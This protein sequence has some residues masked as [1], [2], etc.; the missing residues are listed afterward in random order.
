[1]I[2]IN[3]LS[4]PLDHTADELRAAIVKRLG[5]GDADL[6]D[7]SVFKRSYDARKKNSVILFI[8]IIDLQA[9]D[10]GAILARFADDN[11]VRPAP[12][13]RDYPVGQGP[14]GLS[15]RPRVVGGGPGGQVAALLL[16]QKGF[17]PQEVERG[18]DVRSR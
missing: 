9:R 4:L 8:Y 12:D 1:M 10:E 13:T 14:A 16:A 5:I 3:E 17:R 2:R 15:E 6:L 11:N 18:Q 7:F